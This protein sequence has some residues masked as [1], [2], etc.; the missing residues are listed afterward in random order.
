M[1]SLTGGVGKDTPM[2]T[3]QDWTGIPVFE[4]D[5]GEAIPYP[6]V[7]RLSVVGSAS[8]SDP[9][10]VCSPVAGRAEREGLDPIRTRTSHGAA[11][12]AQSPRSGQYFQVRARQGAAVAASA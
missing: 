4:S 9:D 10:G 1:D 11:A 2:Y 6:T 8:G 12:Q 5:N 3:N 7:E